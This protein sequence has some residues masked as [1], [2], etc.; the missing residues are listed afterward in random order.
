M[1]IVM[2]IFKQ[3]TNELKQSFRV[4]FPVICSSFI[5]RSLSLFSLLT[6]HIEFLQ[7]GVDLPHFIHCLCP[8]ISNFIPCHSSMI[9]NSRHVFFFFIQSRVSDDSTV[10]IF[11]FS[12]NAFAPSAPISFTTIHSFLILSL[13]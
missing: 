11:S 10:F 13:L 2:F 12:L 9:H 1:T 6:S 4:P 7:C 3:S 5:Q 8:L